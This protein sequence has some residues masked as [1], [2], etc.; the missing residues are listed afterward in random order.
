MLQLMVPSTFLTANSTPLDDLHDM[1]AQWGYTNRGKLRGFKLHAFVNQLELPLKA[2][3]TPGNWYDSPFHPKGIEDLEAQ[4]VLAD[5]G[6][7]SKRNNRAVKAIGAEPV[8][9]STPRR[10]KRQKI[11]QVIL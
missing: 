3:V 5:A 10:G 9:A 6:Y 2:V 1:E 7:D 4:Y 8:I 11:K